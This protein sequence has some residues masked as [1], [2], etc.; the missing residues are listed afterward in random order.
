MSE[1]E[2][3]EVTLNCKDFLSQVGPIETLLGSVSYNDIDNVDGKTQQLRTS[4]R[5]FKKMKFD[6]S[7]NATIEKKEKKE[8][9]KPEE[10]KPEI[11]KPVN[12]LWISEEK[13]MF[14]EALNEHGKDFESIHMYISTR[15]K[16]KGVTDDL[17][18][19]KHQ[20]RH[21]YYKTFHMLSGLLKFSDSKAK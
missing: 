15:L 6:L 11:K 18:K 7:N 4:A 1:N 10:P 21:F 9:V 2:N 3:H 8:E 14:F 5:V 17:I 20:I 19:T 13:K 16:K 12:P